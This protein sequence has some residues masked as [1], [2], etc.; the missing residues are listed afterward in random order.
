V[1]YLKKQLAD[2]ETIENCSILCLKNIKGS[3]KIVQHQTQ[4]CTVEE[5]LD[6]YISQDDLANMNE[7]KL[8]NDKKIKMIEQVTS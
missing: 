6:K 8:R 1:Q 5:D 3:R 4:P 2:S 7:L